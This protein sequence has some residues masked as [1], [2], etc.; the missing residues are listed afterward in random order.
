M[1]AFVAGVTVAAPAQARTQTYTVPSESMEPAFSPGQR[2][3][4]DL[5]A[6]DEATP[7]IGDADVFRPPRGAI[8][9]IGECAKRHGRY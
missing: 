3:T 6:Y 9:F 1:L 8:G 2:I 7:E 4:A 5:D